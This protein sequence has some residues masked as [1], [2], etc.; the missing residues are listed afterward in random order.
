MDH[1]NSTLRGRAI[2][3]GVGNDPEL[4]ASVLFLALRDNPQRILRQGRV[5]Q[6]PARRRIA[7]REAGTRL[8]W[9]LCWTSLN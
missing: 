7:D 4:G 5:A 2:T 1:D 9:E 8:L 3:H 6:S